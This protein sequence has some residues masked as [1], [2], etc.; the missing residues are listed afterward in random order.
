MLNQNA[1]STR[2]LLSFLITIVHDEPA[3][4]VM[5]ALTLLPAEAV[6]HWTTGY[7]VDPPVKVR[8]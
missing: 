8:G 2:A 4:A 1:A 5:L 6:I 3:H 7:P